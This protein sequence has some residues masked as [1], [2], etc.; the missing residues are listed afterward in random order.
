PGFFYLG[1]LLHWSTLGTLP[2][3]VIYQALLWLTWLAP[4]ATVY[5]LLLRVVGNGWLALPF[6][7]VAL[8][9]SPGIASGVE[10]GV[11]IGM[12]PARFGWALLPVLALALVDWIEDES[13][14]PWGPALITLA[15]IAV[16]HPAHAPAAATLVI[17]TAFSPPG[18]CARRI[19]EAAVLLGGAAALTSFWS[20]PLL[21]R[22]DQTRAL[23]WGSLRLGDVGSLLT[24]H[25][26]LPLLILLA[27]PVATRPRSAARTLQLWPWATAL[28]VVVDA[29]VAEPL[30]LRWLPA[31]R[32]IDGM[33]IAF[34]VAAG[35]TF[36]SFMAQRERMPTATIVAAVAVV[37]ALG[38]VNRTLVL[39]PRAAD[40]PSYAATARGLQ[41]ESL[42]AALRKTAAGRVLFVRSGVP[43]VFG[44][45]WWRPHTH[46]TALTP[47][48]SEREIVNGTFTHSSPVAKLV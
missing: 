6:A 47:I 15:A 42:W 39:W 31:D 13:R 12:L 40:W 8:T 30:G 24:H 21:L 35:S 33:W 27:L 2:T 26:L 23:A 7:L 48:H 45:E 18:S 25:P 14:P 41:L 37:T 28:V 9:L 3:A 44:L 34:V 43:L 20:L 22:L 17:V 38:A 10:G 16:T 19:F 11:H 46:V 32:I 29:V 4:G 5:T 1:L 36:G